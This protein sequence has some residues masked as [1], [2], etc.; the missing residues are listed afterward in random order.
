M[1]GKHGKLHGALGEE[2]SHALQLREYS[3]RERTRTQKPSGKSGFVISVDRRNENSGK[4]GGGI[5]RRET[6]GSG[7]VESQHPSVVCQLL[8]V[9][10]CL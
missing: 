2:L 6:S 10:G 7:R 5:V 1:I 9:K 3:E 8:P 4:R